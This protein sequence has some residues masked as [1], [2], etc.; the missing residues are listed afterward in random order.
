M[1]YKS[2]LYIAPW[3]KICFWKGSKK[4]KKKGMVLRNFHLN[5]TH[6]RKQQEGTLSLRTATKDAQEIQHGWQELCINRREIHTRLMLLGIQMLDH[7]I[8]SSSTTQCKNHNSTTQKNTDLR[9]QPYFSIEAVSKASHCVLTCTP[10]MTCGKETIGCRPRSP[11]KSHS[12]M[13]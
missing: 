12:H 4:K 2:V 5:S 10:W 3:K 13:E 11:R 8:Q 1:D 9:V 7:Y 6:T